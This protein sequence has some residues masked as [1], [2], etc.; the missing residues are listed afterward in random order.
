MPVVFFL[1]TVATTEEVQLGSLR[2]IAYFRDETPSQL[3][4]VTSSNGLVRHAL[5]GSLPTIPRG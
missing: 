1:P 5:V 3:R 4:G 2:L